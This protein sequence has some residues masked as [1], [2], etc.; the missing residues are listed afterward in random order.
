MYMYMQNQ[1][2]HTQCKYRHALSNNVHVHVPY[3][4]RRETSQAFLTYSTLSQHKMDQVL[5]MYMC[6]YIYMYTYMYM[7]LHTCSMPTHCVH[8]YIIVKVIIL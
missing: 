1:N 7:Y 5:Y 8:M 3:K 2:V 4:I 6:M